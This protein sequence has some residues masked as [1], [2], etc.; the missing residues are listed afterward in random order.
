[1]VVSLPELVVM[2][3]FF[4]SRPVSMMCIVGAVIGL[5]LVYLVLW[6]CRVSVV[7]RVVD[8]L[9]FAMHW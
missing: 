7:C 9:E 2:F 4:L 1:M 5:I 3:S 8:E 6:C